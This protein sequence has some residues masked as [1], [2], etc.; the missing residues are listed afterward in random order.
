VAIAST[1][2]R[3]QPPIANGLIAGSGSCPVDKNPYCDLEKM[4]KMGYFKDGDLICESGG[5]E[6][7]R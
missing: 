3:R 5:M 4:A 6:R 2:Q 7:E 1:P